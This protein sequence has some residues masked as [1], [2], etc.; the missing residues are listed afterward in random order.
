MHILLDCRETQNLHNTIEKTNI[1]GTI[2]LRKLDWIFGLKMQTLNPVIW[3]TNFGKYKAH[4]MA[5]DGPLPVMYEL[6]ERKCY[7]FQ[8]IFWILNQFV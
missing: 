2:A 7:R 6:F 5:L 4:L 1:F 3:I 8:P